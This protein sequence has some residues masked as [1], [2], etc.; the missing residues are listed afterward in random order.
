MRLAPILPQA[1]VAAHF[2]KGAAIFFASGSQANAAAVRAAIWLKGL[3][4]EDTRETHHLYSAHRSGPPKA[5]GPSC[6]WRAAAA[7][8]DGRAAALASYFTRPRT[9]CTTRTSTRLKA[10]AA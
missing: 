1:A 7:V 10:A 8:T 2:G 6:A 5:C 9:W 3:E 4:T